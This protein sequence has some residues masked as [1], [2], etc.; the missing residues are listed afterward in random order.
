MLPNGLE[1]GRSRDEESGR[2]GILIN[3]KGPESGSFRLCMAIDLCERTRISQSKNERYLAPR[4]PEPPHYA[5][6]E[7]LLIE[8]PGGLDAN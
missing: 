2:D 5:W 7:A 8:H 6:S 3:P 4:S 1:T